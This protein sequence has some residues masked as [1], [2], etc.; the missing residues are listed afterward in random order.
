MELGL[1]LEM[2]F[3]K[4]PF[5]ERVKKAADIGF[6][7]VEMWFVDM[8]F[9]GKPDELATIAE[10]GN[11]KITNIGFKSNKKVKTNR[12]CQSLTFGGYLT[13]IIPQRS[14]RKGT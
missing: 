2:A 8:S 3:A 9:K 10:A 1:C 13:I 5:E 14:E 6:K 7:N 11:V 4:L 12:K